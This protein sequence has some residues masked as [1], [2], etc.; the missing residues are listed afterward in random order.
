MLDDLV[1]IEP[2][3]AEDGPFL[4]GDG[5]DD[6]PLSRQY[7]AVWKPTLPSPCTTRRFPSIPTLVPS[8]CISSA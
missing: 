7:L 1:L 8:A 4:L 2:E 6:R 5:D 3:R